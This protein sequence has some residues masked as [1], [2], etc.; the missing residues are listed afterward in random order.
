MSIQRATSLTSYFEASFLY[1]V[2]AS[3]W[4]WNE[5]ITS[6]IHT[7]WVLS[8][9]IYI[10]QSAQMLCYENA[11]RSCIL[12][13]SWCAA[14]SIVHAAASSNLVARSR[15]SGS[16]QLFT[17]SILIR[18]SIIPTRHSF[19]SPQKSNHLSLSPA[20]CPLHSFF[21][22]RPNLPR[23]RLRWYKEGEPSHVSTHGVQ[24]KV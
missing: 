16:I 8:Q 9:H 2:L 18:I 21:S 6:L 11:L 7:Y 12:G 15:L 20:P 14:S 22:Q 17:C 4:T 23:K 3:G 24:R 10:C 1:L 19:F 5:S 13:V